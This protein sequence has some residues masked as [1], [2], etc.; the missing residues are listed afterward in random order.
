MLYKYIYIQIPLNIIN[1]FIDWVFLT[2]NFNEF[3]QL[4]CPAVMSSWPGSYSNSPF[5][6]WKPIPIY[7][8]HSAKSLYPFWSFCM[9]RDQLGDGPLCE[10]SIRNSY[11][12]YLWQNLGDYKYS[13]LSLFQSLI[14]T[15]TSKQKNILQV[16]ICRNAKIINVVI[17]FNSMSH[18]HIYES[19]SVCIY[20]QGWWHLAGPFS[21]WGLQACWTNTQDFWCTHFIYKK[22]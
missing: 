18:R 5:T 11:I 6:A 10:I 15:F 7:I 19:W 14:Q 22:A 20:A 1:M 12:A 9:W 21:T 3:I 17:I 13:K 4:F 16:L 8:S 2:Y